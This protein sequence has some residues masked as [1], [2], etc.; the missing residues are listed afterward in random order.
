V[1]TNSGSY[2]VER[3]LAIREIELRLATPRTLNRLEAALWRIHSSN[4]Q[5]A[6][7]T[8]ARETTRYL[9]EDPAERIVRLLGLF[10]SEELHPTVRLAL[11]TSV[12]PDVLKQVKR[13]HWDDV[14]VNARRQDLLGMGAAMRVAYAVGTRASRDT[15][16]YF[17]DV[18]M[19]TQR[20]DALAALREGQA[21]RGLGQWF[22]RLIGTA[23]PSVWGE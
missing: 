7:Q 8:F 11:K 9:G 21:R 12:L 3:D 17:E 22:A 20:D 4:P 10:A 6:T 16:R 18:W 2:E 15:T 19:E 13:R 1:Q 23:A 5:K 14:R